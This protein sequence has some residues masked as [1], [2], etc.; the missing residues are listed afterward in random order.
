MKLFLINHELN[1]NSHGEMLE[2]ANVVPLFKQGCKEEPG[3][4][5]LILE[6]GQVG[7]RDSERKDIHLFGKARTG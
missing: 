3:N 1:I 6:G 2:V 4:Y 7:R 5:S